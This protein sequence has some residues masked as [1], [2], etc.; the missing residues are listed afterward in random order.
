MNGKTITDSIA[1]FEVLA[2]ELKSFHSVL[3]YYSINLQYFSGE[4]VQDVI[5]RCLSKRMCA[6][7]INYIR[8]KGLMDNTSEYLPRLLEWVSDKIVFWQSELGRNL[9]RGSKNGER[10]SGIF[11]TGSLRLLKQ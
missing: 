10:L 7:F 4:V 5:A 6:E 11:T 3:L 8:T 2:N 9:I 1:D